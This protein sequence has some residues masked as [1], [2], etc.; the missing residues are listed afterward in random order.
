[1]RMQTE[2]VRMFLTVALVT[3]FA[4]CAAQTK[5]RGISVANLSDEQLVEE[6]VS[7]VQ[8]LGMTINRTQYLMAVRPE[9]AYVLTSSTSTFSGVLNANYNTFSMPVGYGTS[10]YGNII[11]STYDVS[12]TQYYYTDV[13]AGAR[14]G[15]AIATAISQAQETAY[16]N[17][18]QEVW[19]EFQRRVETRRAATERLIQEFFSAHPDLES[20]RLL[21]AAVAPWAAA[22]GST[23]GLQTLERSRKIIEGLSRGPGLSGTWYGMLSQTTR[24]D[25]DQEVAFNA[26][27]RI[28]L[29]EDQGRLVG[30]G[31]LGSGEVIELNGRVNGQ[32]IRGAVA[33]TTSAINVSFSGIAASSQITAEYEGIGVG[34]RLTGTVVLL[35]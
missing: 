26:F 4:G 5:Y 20:R 24:T 13:N 33:N 14:L 12:S 30:K 34:Q 25:Q 9:P 2:L 32:Q 27:M 6:L 21:V 19:S 15:N 3:S 16:R 22:E 10:T 31:E 17:R 23:D 18:G 1:M 29:V 35:R 8:G 7:A 11:G 28:K